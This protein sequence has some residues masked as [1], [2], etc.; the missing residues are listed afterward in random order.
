MIPAF[1]VFDSKIASVLKKLLTADISR[2]NYMEEEK[3]TTGQSNAEWKTKCFMI[4]DNY[5]TSLTGE[6]LFDVIAT[7]HGFVSAG[8][9]SEGRRVQVFSIERNGYPLCC[10]TVISMPA[11]KTGLLKRHQLGKETQDRKHGHCAQ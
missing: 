2:R 5:K 6:P 1:G 3:G 10:G 8:Y 4:C 11:M 9:R 7:S